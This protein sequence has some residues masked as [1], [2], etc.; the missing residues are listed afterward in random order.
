[1]GSFA[2]FV[3]NIILTQPRGNWAKFLLFDQTPPFSHTS[4][5]GFT[6]IHWQVYNDK[7]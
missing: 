2:I 4:P 5:M 1:M 3:E 6:N 7:Y